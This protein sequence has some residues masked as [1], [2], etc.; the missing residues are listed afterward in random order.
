MAI[1]VKPG[2]KFRIGVKLKNIGELKTFFPD[3]K[4]A[5]KKKYISRKMA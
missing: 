3:T 2:Y 1:R 4:L 5:E